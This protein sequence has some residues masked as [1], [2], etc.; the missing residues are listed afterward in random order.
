M[1]DVTNNKNHLLQHDSDL[2]NHGER[3]NGHD[4]KFIEHQSLIEV[5]A[6]AITSHGQTLSEQQVRIQT[7]S[8]GVAY[9][10]QRIQENQNSIAINA[11]NLQSLSE[12]YNNFLNSLVKFYVVSDFGFSGHWP[13][14]TGI[15]YGQKILDTHNALDLAS[16]YFTA[17]FNGIYG[18]FFTAV[19]HKW[20]MYNRNNIHLHV[21]DNLVA[22]FNFQYNL[23]ATTETIFFAQYLNAGDRLNMFQAEGAGVLVDFNPATFMGYLMQKA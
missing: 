15:T 16:G 20:D 2:A 22:C 6:G 8:D 1:D 14:N 17:P 10:G 3:L 5:N 11:Q 4:L 12:N 7:N 23:A 13:E 9:N 19:I 18:F 21:N